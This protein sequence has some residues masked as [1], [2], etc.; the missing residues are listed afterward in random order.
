MGAGEVL[1]SVVSM[2]AVSLLTT[3]LW[4]DARG[5]LRSVPIGALSP[6]NLAA[7]LSHILPNAAVAPAVSGVSP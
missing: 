6:A 3:T 4:F 2:H 7:E 5:E 1:T